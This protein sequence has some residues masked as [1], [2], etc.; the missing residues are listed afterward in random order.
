MDIS[1]GDLD[2]LVGRVSPVLLHGVVPVDRVCAVF[3]ITPFL[4]N[5]RSA[6]P[7]MLAVLG[8]GAVLDCTSHSEAGLAVVSLHVELAQRTLELPGRSPVP[9]PGMR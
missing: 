4:I 1:L 6:A 2:I 3:P 5:G 8:G 7:P 9:G